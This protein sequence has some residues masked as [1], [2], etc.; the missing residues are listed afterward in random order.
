[1]AYFGQIQLLDLGSHAIGQLGGEADDRGQLFG[2]TLGRGQLEDGRLREAAKI[3]LEVNLLRQKLLQLE[4][5]FLLQE[6]DQ[7]KK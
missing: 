6:I 2:L 1:M 4:L 3:G 7:V 5:N